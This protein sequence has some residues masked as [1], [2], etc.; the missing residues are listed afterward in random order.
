M[1]RDY[2]RFLRGYSANQR[3]HFVLLIGIESVG[4]LVEDQNIGIM[5]HGLRDADATLEAFGQGIDALV[6]DLRE[7]NAI[8]QFGH[9][10]VCFRL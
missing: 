9:P 1:R 6:P 4:W 2:D 5:H 8:D 3:P 10:V 7:T